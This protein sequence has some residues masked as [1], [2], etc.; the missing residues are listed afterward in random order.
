VS[1][2]DPAPD[3]EQYEALLAD[4]DEALA[5]GQTP[6]ALS[7]AGTPP[8]LP[9]GM[10][11]DLACIKLL[12][13]WRPREGPAAPPPGG[14]PPLR[15]GHFEI[16][17]E[18]G[19]GGFGVVFLA[20]DSRLRREVA[21]K[22]PRADALV[23][24]ELRARFRQEAR[25]AGALDHPNLVPVYE[26]GEVGAV[27]YIASA[28]CPGVTLAQRLK[29]RGEPMAGP[30]AAAL[31]APLAEAVQHAHS[32]GVL[33]R[34][35][36][37]GN[38]LLHQDEASVTPKVTDFGL[39]KLLPGD[40]PAGARESPTV[41]GAVV[42]TPS[43]MAPEQA[44]GTG[45]DITTAVDVYALGAI[46]YE[47]LTGQP[48]FR[49]ETALEALDKMRAGELVPPRRLRP[50]LARDLETICLKCLHREP[51]RRYASAGALADDLRRYLAGEPIQARPAGLGERARRWA[52]R[53]PAAAALVGVSAA[54][55]LAVA[56]GGVWHVTQLRAALALAEDRELEAKHQWR[57]AEDHAAE[58]GRQRLSAERR[59]R[60]AA[61]AVRVM[62]TRVGETRLANMPYMEPHRRQ[63]LE[64]ALQFN[65]ALLNEESDDA[66]MRAETAR[67]YR[68]VGGIHH[69]LGR[70]PRAEQAYRRSVVLYER[71]VAEFPG[72][73]EYRAGLA[74]TWNGLGSLLKDR[75]RP[76]E[77]ER[78]IRRGLAI[79]VELSGK[80][81]DVPAYTRLRA[82]SYRNLG[83]HLLSLGPSRECEQAYRQ[84]VACRKNWSPATP[85][86]R[87][88]VTT[89]RPRSRLSASA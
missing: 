40:S 62:L 84:A 52:R 9:R 66:P 15:L 21:L 82:N 60:K 64:D 29:E 20:F 54:A 14:E 37:P 56:A 71:L 17:R 63:L 1:D 41:S 48:P 59:Y 80:Y 22:V 23:T 35:L 65:L 87:P 28:Y 3:D 79:L 42:G 73:P 86:W 88:T 51:G 31:L 8:G 85:G 68:E 58:A 11:R 49:A 46:L 69:L 74:D 76:K 38:I 75:A 27:C 77:A 44:A 72:K 45:K 5:T 4:C 6:S 26:A 55:L 12:R 30:E 18:L 34:D 83:T 10:E 47:A 70:L 2:H 24:P 50:A 19:R 13:Q 89:W 43:Y 67:T 57:R 81:P 25:A 33:H 78:A 61:D 36:K 39:A 53:R 32:R 16:R 7:P